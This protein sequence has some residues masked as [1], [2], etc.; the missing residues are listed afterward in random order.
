MAMELSTAATLTLLPITLSGWRKAEV[1]EEAARNRVVQCCAGWSSLR[2]TDD[3]G[4]GRS[5][6][7]SRCLCRF[8]NETIGSIST[9]TVNQTWRCKDRWRRRRRA[10][11]VHGSSF[12][13]PKGNPAG[14][15]NHCCVQ[16]G[17]G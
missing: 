4:Q 13:R 2:S 5:L 9:R 12:L 3:G 11:R 1:D 16:H 8:Q 15:S 14:T 17:G 6:S 7:N 10:S